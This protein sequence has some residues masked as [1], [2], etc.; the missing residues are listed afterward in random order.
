MKNASEVHPDAQ[1]L[2]PGQ[3]LGALA[4]RQKPSNDI[5]QIGVDDGRFEMVA[6]VVPRQRFVTEEAASLGE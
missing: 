5:A 3:Q 2:L 6:R 1:V 4:N